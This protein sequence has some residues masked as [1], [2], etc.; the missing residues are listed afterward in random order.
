MNK[1]TS[2]TPNEFEILN[3]DKSHLSDQPDQRTPGKSIEDHARGILARIANTPN[4]TVN[5]LGTEKLPL[6][7]NDDREALIMAVSREEAKQAQNNTTLP[8]PIEIIEACSKSIERVLSPELTEITLNT[9]EERFFKS[10]FFA[11]EWHKELIWA[12]VKA[13]LESSPE[14][15]W[16]L[17]EM[18]VQQHRPMLYHFDE[19]GFDIGTYSKIVPPNTRNCVYDKEAEEQLRVIYPESKFTGNAVEMSTAMGINLMTPHQY[20]NILQTKG[21]FDRTSGSWLLTDKATRERGNALYGFLHEGEGRIIENTAYYH[22]DI[23]GW[24]GT[25]RV[26]WA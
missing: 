11:S 26:S 15:L 5:D 23:L 24:R 13:S 17:N 20:R 4:T 2:T 14:V 7:V 10:E 12:R 21:K 1:I 6:R 22:S 25:L 8:A 16:T 19:K 9:F 18:E 3:E